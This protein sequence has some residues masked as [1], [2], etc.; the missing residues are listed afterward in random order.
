VQVVQGLYFG[1]TFLMWIVEA[2]VYTGIFCFRL[3]EINRQNR[4][5]GALL[6]ELSHTREVQVLTSLTVLD[7]TSG[8]Q[9]GLQKRVQEKLYFEQ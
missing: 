8:R 7:S 6:D 2:Y 9:M 3:F 4:L 5:P 1:G